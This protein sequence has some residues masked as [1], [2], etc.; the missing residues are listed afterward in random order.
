[1]LSIQP[2]DKQIVALNML[3][4][5]WHQHRTYMLYAPVGFGKTAV[6]AFI[7]D[8]LIS[9]GMRVL[10][11]APYTVLIDQT[12][13][14]FT[15]YG[16]DPY[17]ISIIWQNHP[18]FNPSKNLQIAS[19]DTLIRRDMPENIDL[20][21]YDEAHLRRVGLLKEFEKI[22]SRILGLSGSPFSKWLGNYYE[23]MLKPA[24][25]KEL[26]SIG[27]LS[28]YEFYAPVIPD[29]SNVKTQS[30][31]LGVDYNETDL[32]RIM[33]GSDLIGNIV[34]NWLENGENR[35]TICFCVTVNHANFVM[36]E[37]NK[38]GVPAEV[39]TA[40]TPHEERQRIVN[41][42]ELGI[43]KIIVNVGVLVAGFDSDVRCI[44]Y[45]RPTKSEIRW[46]QCLGRGLR[47]AD[48]KDKCIIFD[49]SGTV[50]R[51]G[52][53]DDIEYEFLFDTDTG[54]KKSALVRKQS[55]EK[56]P[57]ECPSCKYVKPTGVYECPKCGFK[58][59]RSENVETDE[60]RGLH[61]IKSKK[62]EPTHEEKQGFWSE[63]KYYQKERSLHGKPLSDGWCANTYKSKFG[64]YP[65]GLNDS[66]IETSPE[67]RN[68]IKHLFIKFA[69]SK[70]FHKRKAA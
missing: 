13:R 65:R 7:T 56:L 67:T 28:S 58:P 66:L 36:L 20:I 31:T 24:T 25:M 40:K 33:C 63:L 59:V 60:S 32:D 17:D 50:H 53:P 42:F 22:D 62:K 68:Y 54:M 37:F 61:K 29:L 45:A 34:Q 9:R 15:E 70:G 57:K 43:T 18:S 69:K 3:R 30:T 12:V 6:A 47:N 51:L 11:I 41:R 14:R 52:F 23:V 5:A 44:I 1:M 26:I 27:D 35:A 4:Q 46:I 2:R 55:E 64:V 21:I 16:I 10:F 48:G 38:Q 8:G 39:M 19:A 49:H